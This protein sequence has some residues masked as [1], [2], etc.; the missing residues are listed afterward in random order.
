MKSL[1]NRI[2]DRIRDF[3]ATWHM[4]IA[5]AMLMVMFG[6]GVSSMAGNSAIVDEVAHI[7]S[8]YSYLHYGDYRLNPEHPPLMKDLAGLPLQFMH[9]KFPDDKPAWTT[10]VN[11]QWDTGWDFLYRMGNNADAILMWS[12]LPIFAL[13]IGFGAF[14]YWFARRKWGTAVALIT[15]FFYTLS[16]N[17]LAHSTVVTTD[18]GASVF[19][20]LAIVTFARFADKPTRDNVLLLSLALAGAQ[21]A[22]FSSALLY[23]LLAVIT[24]GLVW[25]AK[26]PGTAKERLKTYTGGFLAGSG[27]FMRT[28]H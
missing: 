5:A 10:N 17:L 19:I 23:P 11:G 18:L 22:K 1:Y 13:A 6:L 8:A 7:P 21:V 16:P 28:G 27:I 26:N 9:V 3:I 20:F 15:L 2:T 25:L 24:L 14:L 4:Y 12:R